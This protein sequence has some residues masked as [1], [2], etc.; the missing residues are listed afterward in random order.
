MSPT[1]PPAWGF[2]GESRALWEVPR[3][4][5]QLPGLYGLPRGRNER[6]V[7]FPGFGAGD[8]SMWPLRT[9]LRLLGHDA[10]GWGLGTNGGDVPSLVERVVALVDRARRADGRPVRLIGWSLGGYLARE[11]ARERPDAVERV[12]TLGSP[13][14]G[15]PKYTAVAGFYRQRGHDLDAIEA[16]VAARDRVPIT[17]PITAIYSRSDRIVSWQACIDRTSPCVEHVEVGGS[18]TGLGLNPDV[19]RIVAERLALPR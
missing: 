11:A 2:L 12:V 14:V 4:A 13:V 3:L 18:H 16:A 17:V 6:V 1:P 10:C 7:L 5:F 19:Y 15:G 9:F 8:P